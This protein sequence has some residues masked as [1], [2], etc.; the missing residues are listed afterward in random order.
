MRQLG[1]AVATGF[2]LLGAAGIAVRLRLGRRV[3]T[4]LAAATLAT[5]QVVVTVLFAGLVV[6]RLSPWVLL[7]S[8]VVI[9][10]PSIWLTRH[11]LRPA[12][13]IATLRRVR[14]RRA[15]SA[16]RRHPWSSVLALGA[17][18]QLVWRTVIGVVI[19]PY[20]WDGLWYHLPSVA[21]WVAAGRIT[22]VPY[23]LWSNIFPAN[24]E[25][26]T[27]W[28]AVFTHSSVGLAA[29]QLP[30]GV[31][32][33]VAV[34]SLARTVGVSRP[35]AV[36]A[37]SLFFLTPVVLAQTTSNYVDLM[38]A[39]LVLSSMAFGLRLLSAGDPA[40]RRRLAVL[41]G[42]A[43]GLAIGTKSSA[44]PYV[45]LLGLVL[46]ARLASTRTRDVRA[47]IAFALPV[48]L[49]GGFWFVRIWAHYGSPVHPFAVHVGSVGVFNGP[50]A[51]SDFVEKAPRQLGGSVVLQPLRAWFHD[52]VSW[53]PG[54]G[55]YSY[56]QRMGGFGAVWLLLEIPICAVLTWIA[57]RRRDVAFLVL[58]LV[59]FVG[60]AVQPYRWWTRFS[61]ALVAPGAIALAMAIERAPRR[62]LRRGLALLSAG[63]VI[64]AAGLASKSLHT[65]TG[66]PLQATDVVRRAFHPRLLGGPEPD[67]MPASQWLDRV[68]R[69]API[70]VESH[71]YDEEFYFPVFGLHL[72][73]RLIPIRSGTPKAL[74]DD[75]RASGATVLVAITGSDIDRWAGTDP[76]HF[77]LVSGTHPTEDIGHSSALARAYRF[78]S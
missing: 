42:I 39:A 7:V 8:T 20:G 51:A 27:T 55:Q 49:I 29:A 59:P 72:S 36:A 44:V 58:V 10:G 30:Y 11:E 3:D 33:A 24:G 23:A 41:C 32:G 76:R 62:A 48:V 18:G 66:T 73:H 22:S 65:Y 16:A 38:T 46:V 53:R 61:I 4:L 63:L 2:A 77:R 37:G 15:W 69:N 70:G 43:G 45:A 71:P 6:R 28:L 67:F 78:Q 74:V 17:L 54:S 26:V 25:V 40:L 56:D 60:F 31:V 64:V 13:W 5:L 19:P 12:N 52:V 21:T 14:V 47:L 75:V 57:V 9:G 50:V 35:G 1:L 68:D 34:M